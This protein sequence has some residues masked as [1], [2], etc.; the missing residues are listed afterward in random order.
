MLVKKHKE[1]WLVEHLQKIYLKTLTLVMKFKKAV[2]ILSGILLLVA[3]FT[4]SKLGRSFLPEFN[5]GSLVI[6]VVSLTGIS[7]EEGNRIGS[8]VEMKL[9]SIPEISIT[10]R[11]TGRA[12]LDEHAQGVN[13]SEIDAPFTLKERSRDEF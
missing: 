12:E 13:A 11:R 7:L 10:T 6:S 1:S 8:E 9:L 3:I 5:E 4:M 2:L